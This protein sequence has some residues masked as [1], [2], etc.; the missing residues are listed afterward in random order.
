MNPLRRNQGIAFNSQDVDGCARHD[1]KH[2]SIHVHLVRTRSRHARARQDVRRRSRGCDGVHLFHEH[3]RTFVSFRIASSMRGSISSTSLPTNARNG[4]RN[5]A[6][7]WKRILFESERERHQA[8][9][10]ASTMCV[11][12]CDAPPFLRLCYV[13]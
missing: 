2:P 9:V 13:A 7:K 12:R 3:R 1:V 10:E 8:F 11:S 5:E 4:R 6:R